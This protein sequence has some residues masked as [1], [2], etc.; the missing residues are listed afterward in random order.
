MRS[1]EREPSFRLQSQGPTVISPT[2]AQRIVHCLSKNVL[3]F[4]VSRL[5][6]ALPWVLSN[7]PAKCEF[8][9]TN[10]SQDTWITDRQ[11]YCFKDT[12]IF[13][14]LIFKCVTQRLHK[15]HTVSTQAKAVASRQTCHIQ[16]EWQNLTV[17]YFD[18]LSLT[19][20]VPLELK[21]YSSCLS[22]N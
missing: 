15:W 7:K 10:G 6:T 20:S 12:Y 21:E 5:D 1:P 9:P 19:C 2:A 8:G 11:I 22:M 18:F 13:K 14:V 4:N 17:W 16:A 3:I